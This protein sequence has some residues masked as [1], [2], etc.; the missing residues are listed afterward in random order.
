MTW[1]SDDKMICKFRF[2]YLRL[3]EKYYIH[4]F[5]LNVINNDFLKCMN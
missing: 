5:F 4:H 2:M 3:R 1:D